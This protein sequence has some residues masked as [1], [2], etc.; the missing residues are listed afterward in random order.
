MD[1]APTKPL[2]PSAQRV[3]DA[4]TAAGVVTTVTEYASSART[5][6]EAAVVLGCTVGEIAS[7]LKKQFGVYQPPTR[8]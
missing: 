7:A 6:A 8:F 1:E 5:S 4:L 2:S 3:Q